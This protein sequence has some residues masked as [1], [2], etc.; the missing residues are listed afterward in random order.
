MNIV[1][2]T[3]EDCGCSSPKVADAKPSACQFCGKQPR[4]WWQAAYDCA[5]PQAKAKERAAR[6]AKR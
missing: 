1:V 5:P 3:C 2:V 4:K 6:R